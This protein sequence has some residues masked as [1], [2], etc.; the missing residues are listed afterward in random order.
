[1]VSKIEY[2]MRWH[3]RLDYLKTIRIQEI[4]EYKVGMRVTILDVIQTYY[5]ETEWVEKNPI[6]KKWTLV[7][8]SEVTVH[9]AYDKS[10]W[11]SVKLNH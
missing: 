7:E 1:M 4:N 11:V 10:D 8:F 6:Y 5:N 3:F 2:K 9:N